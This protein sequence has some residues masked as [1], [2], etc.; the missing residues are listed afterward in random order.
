MPWLFPG[1]CQALL[2]AKSCSLKRSLLLLEGEGR[3]QKTR[4]VLWTN[5]IALKMF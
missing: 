1:H 4:T 3:G 2:P 5:L